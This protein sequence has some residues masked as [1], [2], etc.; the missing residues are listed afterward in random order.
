MKK[1]EDDDQASNSSIVWDCG[2]PLYDSFELVSLVHLIERNMMISL[3]LPERSSPS[4]T[5]SESE[6]DVLNMR[7]FYSYKE[8][9]KINNGNKVRKLKREFYC[10]CSSIGNLINKGEKV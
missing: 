8:G 1:G 7:R 2:S 3:P 5:E 10:F 6:T 4:T 9:E